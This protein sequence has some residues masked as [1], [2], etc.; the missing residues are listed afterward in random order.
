MTSS[1]VQAEAQGQEFIPVTFGGAQFRVPLDVDRW[2]LDLIRSSRSWLIAEKRVIVNHNVVVPALSQL[3]GD[4]WDLFITVATKR[5]DFVKATNDFAAAVGIPGSANDLVFGGIPGL[6]WLCDNWP[7]RVEA[8]LNRFWHIDYRDRWRFDATGHRLLTLRRIHTCTTNLPVDSALAIAMNNG[9]LHYTNGD[10]LLMDVWEAVTHQRH[11]ARPMPP[12]EAK[13][14]DEKTE[15]DSKTQAAHRERMDKRK[16][17]QTTALANAQANARISQ[18]VAQHAQ[19]S[20][21]DHQA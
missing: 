7:T 16:N 19:R 4:Q 2:P 15:I 10:F 14:R 3:I 17:R 21:E 6:L 18:G 11:P 12:E 9:K 20:S 5:R 1:P 8:D 13:K